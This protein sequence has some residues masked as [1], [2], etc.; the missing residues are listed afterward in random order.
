[1]LDTPTGIRFVQVTDQTR[2]PVNL[3]AGQEVAIDYT[4][5]DQGVMIAKD[6]RLISDS[7]MADESTTQAQQTE[8]NAMTDQRSEQTESETMESGSMRTAETGTMD[9]STD[10]TSRATT[11]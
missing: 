9:Q 10:A 11:R 8:T 6:V 7:Q 1:M 2:K 3:E 4:R 5:T